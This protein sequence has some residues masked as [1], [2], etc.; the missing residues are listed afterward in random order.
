MIR[1][2]H[3]DGAHRDL[4]RIAGDACAAGVRALSGRA[5]RL[6]A[7]CWDSRGGVAGLQRPGDMAAALEAMLGALRDALP[8][9]RRGDFRVHRL[10]DLHVTF[11]GYA[12]KGALIGAVESWDLAV[13]ETSAAKDLRVVRRWPLVVAADASEPVARP[14][15]EELRAARLARLAPPAS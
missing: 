7:A 12:Q 15:A 8:T 13:V 2:D 5:F 9:M 3:A 1:F 14:S 6:P 11:P 4:E 10:R